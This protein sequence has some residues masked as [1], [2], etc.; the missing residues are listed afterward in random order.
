MSMT[1][2]SHQ[3]FWEIDD[4]FQENAEIFRETPKKGR[5]IISEKICPPFLKFW[6]R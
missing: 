3:K 6:I 1:K 5:S 2:K 4:N